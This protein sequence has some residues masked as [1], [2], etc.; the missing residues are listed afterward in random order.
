MH[1]HGRNCCCCLLV[2]AVAAACRT[3]AAAAAAV[4]TIA[5]VFVYSPRFVASSRYFIANVIVVFV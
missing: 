4:A 3:A 2:I 1:D 5:V